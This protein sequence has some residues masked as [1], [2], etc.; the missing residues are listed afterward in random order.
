MKKHEGSAALAFYRRIGTVTI[1]NSVDPR[2]AVCY[3]LYD[4][5]IISKIGLTFPFCRCL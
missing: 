5:K 3:Q 1:L 4:L 2:A